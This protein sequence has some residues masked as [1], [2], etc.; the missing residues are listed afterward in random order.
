MQTQGIF[1]S[2]IVVK[3]VP[4]AIQFYTEVAGLKLKEYHKEFGW[5][6]LS[7]PSGCLLGIAQEN[8]EESVKA[9]GNAVITITV[10]DIETA[11]THFAEKGADLIGE[12]LE[13]PGHVKLQTFVDV[14]GN[15]LQLVENLMVH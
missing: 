10:D 4:K 3:D 6:E 11:K 5:A 9:G 12:T 15:T 1:L 8:A 2:W 14:D 13:I 7:G